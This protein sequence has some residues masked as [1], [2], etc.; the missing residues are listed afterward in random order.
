V[1]KKRMTVFLTLL[2]IIDFGIIVLG[3]TWLSTTAIISDQA[4]GLANFFA[5]YW[6]LNPIPAECTYTVGYWKTHIDD[7][8]VEEITLG[9]IT[10]PK[11]DALNILNLPPSGDATLILGWQLISAKLNY[12]NGADTSEIQSALEMSDAWLVEHP[13]GSNPP[14]PE[15]EVGIA[16]AV[17]LEEYNSGQSGPGLCS[18]DPS[19]DSSTELEVETEKVTPTPEAP[20]AITET[21]SLLPLVTDTVTPTPE[22]PIAITKTPS[23]LP[24]VTDTATLKPDIDITS[25]PTSSFPGKPTELILPVTPTM[26]EVSPMP[27]PKPVTATPTDMIESTPTAH[28]IPTKVTIIPTGTL[29]PTVW[30]GYS[31]LRI[32]FGV[33][34]LGNNIGKEIYLGKPFQGTGEFH[35]EE[36]YDWAD[37]IHNITF[38]HERDENI[39][40]TSIDSL[41]GKISMEYV[42]DLS[43]APVCPITRSTVLNI[44][45]I[46]NLNDGAVSLNQL[47][48]NDFELGDFGPIDVEGTFM[49][50]WSITGFDFHQS[51]VIMGDIRVQNYSDI[52]NMRLELKVGCQP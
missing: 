41:A 48:L 26:S 14:N 6:E 49:K 44:T 15:R 45:L 9:A 8:P 10:Y 5:G 31:D 18:D 40:T 24:L 47:V 46:D 30:E 2:L 36:D 52:E 3:S 17:I 35:V 32:A 4:D 34:Y 37:G 16:F 39:I 50:S 20:I 43:F 1:K 27:F 28:L 25:T 7:W 19:A 51:F 23:L 12:F 11:I 33:W 38:T 42:L 29:T 13:L 22:A 21:P